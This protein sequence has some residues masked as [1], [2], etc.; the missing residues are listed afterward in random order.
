MQPRSVRERI[1]VCGAG[2]HILA[3]VYCWPRTTADGVQVPSLPR[4]NTGSRVGRLCS[5]DAF[6][7]VM[8]ALRGIC[9][10]EVEPR[11]VGKCAAQC[12]RLPCRWPSLS[13]HSIE[14]IL[15][16]RTRNGVSATLWFLPVCR[17][18]HGHRGW[19]SASAAY[20]R[21]AP[22]KCRILN[23]H[24]TSFLHRILRNES[25][26]RL[27]TACGAPHLPGRTF[28]PQNSTGPQDRDV[29]IIIGV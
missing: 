13:V 5:N 2:E 25:I 18:S 8:E 10:H 1:H 6:S 22:Q 28:P 3:G 9:G 19:A 12:T 11:F 27:V 29:I 26:L 16:E 17:I 14:M 23:A 21:T 15:Q 7:G 4:M 20:D 24:F